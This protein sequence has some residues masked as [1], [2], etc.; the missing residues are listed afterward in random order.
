MLND[1]GWAERILSMT[2]TRT[3]ALASI[4]EAFLTL[5]LKHLSRVN[6]IVEYSLF[7]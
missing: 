6:V 3:V 4:Y 2:L 7:C 5:F 1:I